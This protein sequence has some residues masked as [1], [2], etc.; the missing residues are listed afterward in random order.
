M[1]NYRNKIILKNHG[2]VEKNSLNKLTET[3][4]GE[5]EHE[6][7][8]FKYSDY[9]DFTSF[10]NN[11]KKFKNHFTVL[12]LNIQGLKAKFNELVVI[13]EDLKKDEIYFSAICL[14]ETHL[15]FDDSIAPFN[16]AGYDGIP[17]KR[18]VSTWG[19]LVTYFR[20]DLEIEPL[21]L[22]KESKIWEGQFFKIN[23]KNF[24]YTITLGN[25]YKSSKGYNI[26]DM[27]AFINE[28]EPIVNKLSQENNELILVGDFNIN[29]LKCDSLEL[30]DEFFE[31]FL[32]RGLF[33]NI[34]LPT[35]VTKN[36]ATL[37]DQIYSKFDKKVS[38][39]NFAG[40]IDSNLS[41]HFPIFLCIPLE[42]DKN[43]YS[44]KIIIKNN[45]MEDIDKFKC[46]L[47]EVDWSTIVDFGNQ[48]D[49]NLKY[50]NFI[51]KFTNIQNECIKDKEVKFNKY[52]HAY[53]PW[54]NPGL[55]RSIKYRDRLYFSLKKTNKDNP[56]YNSKQN[57]LRNY[58]KL[59]RKLIN[60]AK[61][62][63]SK[64]KLEECKSDIK[65]TWKFIN[66]LISTK[67]KK[68]LSE[69]MLDENGTKIYDKLKIANKFNDYF[70]NTSKFVDTS[71]SA[72]SN[73]T[74]ENYLNRLITS[75]FK[76]NLINT[77]DLDKI[78]QIINP[79]NSKGVD[80]ISTNILKKVYSS[81]RQPLLFLIN[82][83]LKTG[84]F[85]NS[86][87]IANVIPVYKKDSR[88]EF[89]NYRPISVLPAFSKI[90]E[91]CVQN[92][93]YQYFVNNKLLLNSQ[94]GFQKNCSTELAAVDFIEY[95]KDEIGKKHLPIG[96]FLDLSKAFDTVN[97][98]ILL[99]KLN[100]YGVRNNELNWF[101]SYL[102]NRSQFVTFDSIKSEPKQIVS[103]VPQG[104]ILG[105]LL[106]LIY[107][108]DLN[109]VSNYFKTILFADDS[110]L[111]TT[112][113]FEKYPVQLHRTCN[114]N[115]QQSII[116][117]EL[118]K[119]LNWLKVNMLSLNVKKTK[120][121]LFH[122]PQ[123]QIPI[124]NIP[125][126]YINNMEIERVEEFNFLGITINC[127]CTWKNHLFYT[128]KKIS[129]NIGLL[130][131]LKFQLPK[132]CLKLIYFALVHPYLNYGIL[133][134][135]F[136]AK[137]IFKLQKRAVRVITKS[138]FLAHTDPLFKTEKILKVEDI[139]K[140]S[141]L[142][143]YYKLINN[144][145]PIHIKKLFNFNNQRHFRVNTDFHL[146]DFNCND[147]KG[148]KRI[149]YYLPVLIKDIENSILRKSISLSISSFKL[150]LKNYF[151][152]KYDDTPCHD[153]NCY[154]CN[155]MLY[156]YAVTQQI[157]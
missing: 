151:L 9:Q 49:I 82:C 18:I 20:N 92:Q 152:Y 58:N 148:K 133:L 97:H 74:F 144:Q 101:K 72:A 123:R 141:C 126:I 68:C 95:I 53:N 90:F 108:N 13:I 38:N 107:I 109:Y 127:N 24:S 1:A 124:N 56:S 60:T 30:Y 125:K 33:P 137:N 67:N 11:I 37:I 65:N 41:D 131:M 106:F 130:S 80:N 86:L 8:F 59:L 120:Y 45:S 79:K 77:F 10:K 115:G 22:Y 105:P 104:S 55:I 112:I 63:Y 7:K 47:N 71:T 14:Q 121:M 15:E 5:N 132:H 138:H 40:I 118:K 88:F 83:S 113:C 44:K 99:K 103:G 57:N 119:I 102:F 54:I 21:N 136:E 32:T 23:S 129:K 93:L 91:K 140:A 69:Y 156:H 78:V 51:N 146:I 150:C 46:A 73:V 75:E 70:I 143:L 111:G 26:A 64:S 48:N 17:Q 3:D 84:V 89:S 157:A 12:S 19:G 96:I 155:S 76:F 4:T 81:I 50:D 100:F 139:F 66:T 142:K 128:S 87:K 36:T 122:N 43:K 42:F 98:N 110:T 29:L 154:P 62:N 2:G 16:I 25:F 147:E 31:M 153:L 114:K 134:W 34:T 61:N 94:Y 28:T 149:R 135:G 145:L 116:N 27:R 52:K 39:E 117:N 6:I 85:P 35:R